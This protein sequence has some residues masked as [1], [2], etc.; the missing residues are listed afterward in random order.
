MV[1]LKIPNFITLPGTR[2]NYVV[3]RFVSSLAVATEE[4]CMDIFVNPVWSLELLNHFLQVEN[5][6]SCSMDCP[7]LKLDYNKIISVTSLT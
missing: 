4:R 5:D 7:D 1:S 3:S 6:S 2:L